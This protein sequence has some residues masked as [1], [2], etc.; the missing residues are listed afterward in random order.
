MNTSLSG[1]FESEE[2]NLGQDAFP[3]L[4]FVLGGLTSFLAV[5]PTLHVESN[6]DGLALRVLSGV[7]QLA[8]V[9]PHRCFR[10]RFV[11]GHCGSP[12]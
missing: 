6:R 8:D 3:L 11:E 1:A 5:R 7:Q 4:G 10:S 9:P 2:T 12:E